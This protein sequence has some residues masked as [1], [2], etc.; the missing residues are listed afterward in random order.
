[1]LCFMETSELKSNDKFA[2]EITYFWGR[3]MESA[4]EAAFMS[5]NK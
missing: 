3:Q 2:A 5:D 4:W 1:M